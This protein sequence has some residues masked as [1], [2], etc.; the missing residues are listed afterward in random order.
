[1]IEY[2]Q[3]E[4]EREC[5]CLW[6]CVLVAVT[7]SRGGRDEGPSCRS[8]VSISLSHCMLPHAPLCPAPLLPGIQTAQAHA[9]T[10]AR[11]RIAGLGA[12]SAPELPLTFFTP[13]LAFLVATADWP[14][15]FTQ[16]PAPRHSTHIHTHIL[17]CVRRLR[18][19]GRARK[20]ETITK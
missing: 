19:S 2:M 9:C 10:H 16:A 18:Q 6:P 7:E 4:R 14:R 20:A 1:M 8:L 5:V 13:F 15:L 3:R 12:S 11:G 17:L